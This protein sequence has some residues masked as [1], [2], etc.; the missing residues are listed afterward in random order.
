MAK[1][2]EI[3]Y[4]SGSGYE[5][6][7]PKTLPELTGCLPL[8]GGTLTGPLTL[9]GEPSGEMEAVNKGYV[10]G[11][12][13]NV[14][15]LKQ[16]LLWTVTATSTQ[17]ANGTSWISGITLTEPPRDYPPYGLL[18]ETIYN[19]I[20][21]TFDDVDFNN[22]AGIKFYMGD[23]GGTPPKENQSDGV[24]VPSLVSANVEHYSGT[25][26]VFS[27]AGRMDYSED[28]GRSRPESMFL[29][30]NDATINI[31]FGFKDYIGTNQ[32]RYPIIYYKVEKINTVYSDTSITTNFYLAYDH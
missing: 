17:I 4:N 5:V 23:S 12:G 22:T 24:L 2:I 10:D 16:V 8:T 27:F 30:W 26:S 9:S 15:A 6:L 1:N 29:F 14:E 31:S 28:G 20:T 13:I 19:N 7:Y 25:L 11:R 21:I 18:I 32:M 3:N